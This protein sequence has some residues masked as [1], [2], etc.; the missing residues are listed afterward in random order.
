MKKWVLCFIL[1][2]MG[3]SINTSKAEEL[4]PFIAL[5]TTTST[6]NSGLL[7]YLNDA[8]TKETGIEV[9]VIAKGTGAALEIAKNGD[10][11]IVMVHDKSQ[12]RRFVREGYGTERL[13]LM[14][15]DFILV[16]PLTDPAT[17]KGLPIHAAMK[18]ICKGGSFI[19]R[20]DRSG[21]NSREVLLWVE[22]GCRPEGESYMSVGQGMGKTLMIASEKKAYTLSDRATFLAYQKKIELQ[23]ISEGGIKLQNIYSV[24]PVNPE[25]HPHAKIELAMK[26]AN[27]LRSETGQKLIADFRLENQQVF[28]PDVIVTPNSTQE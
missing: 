1:V 7:A 19:S 11:D 2:I 21:T 23:I 17:A 25:K 24:I 20:G 13:S 8:F 6:D 3:A 28:F 15:N 9:R 26:Y 12:E 18:K 5:A 4:K 22:T 27:W 16:G 10:A 14:H